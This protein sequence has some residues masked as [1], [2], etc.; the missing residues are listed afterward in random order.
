MISSSTHSYQV[1]IKKGLRTQ[2]KDHLDKKYAKVLVITDSKVGPLYLDEVINAF[3]EDV[4]VSHSIVSAGEASKSME[5]YSNLLNACITNQLDRNSLI[6]GLGGGMV[7]DLSGFVASTYLRGVDFLQMPTSIL[8]H[9]SS[10]GGKVAINHKQGK[11][12]IGC[13]YSPIQVIYDTETLQ[14]LPVEEIRSGYGEVVKHALLSDMSWC[15]QL[16][17]E[18]LSA[19]SY[20]QLEDHLTL[21]IQVKAEVVEQDEKE[22]GV[23]RHLNLGHTLAH[24]MEAELGYGEI[25]HGEAVAIGIWFA[26]KISEDS[27]KVSLPTKSYVQWLIKNEYPIDTLLKVNPEKL[28][29]RMRWDKK[30]IDNNIHFVLLE[31]VGSPTVEKISET[32][33]HQYLNDFVEEVSQIDKR[34]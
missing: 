9:D 34:N 8:A 20:Q 26:M 27:F 25:T 24:A 30:T 19:L 5:Q 1:V 18:D 22:H 16:L 13:F 2:L 23:R 28:V 31:A 12:L 32:K 7:G 21:G 14:T 4:E 10:V 29:N 6:I 17:V 11:N 33:L 15:E 3:P